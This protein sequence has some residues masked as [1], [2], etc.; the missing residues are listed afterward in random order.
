MAVVREGRATMR[1]E[2]I[3]AVMMDVLAEKCGRI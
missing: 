2:E 3:V 1:K